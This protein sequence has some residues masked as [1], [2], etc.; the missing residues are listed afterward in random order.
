MN[1]DRPLNSDKPNDVLRWRIRLYTR[2][3]NERYRN[4]M[5]IFLVLV[6]DK[7]FNKK[8]PKEVFYNFC[9]LNS[10]NQRVNLVRSHDSR[11]FY[12]NETWGFPKFLKKK[13][14]ESDYNNLIPN[15]Q[16]TIIVELIVFGQISTTDKID[17]ERKLSIDSR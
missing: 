9:L 17:Q 5:G 8:L 14:I 10:Q 12:E 15:D 6:Q 11:E 2:G 1:S 4:Y 13:L 7:S 3:I 16:M